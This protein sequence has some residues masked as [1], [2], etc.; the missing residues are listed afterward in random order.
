MSQ[1]TPKINLE[2]SGKINLSS[3]NSQFLLPN[4]GKYKTTE[5]QTQQGAY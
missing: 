1:Q 5:R 4:S 2:Q 3:S